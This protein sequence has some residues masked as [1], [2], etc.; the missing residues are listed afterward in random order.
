MSQ[1]NRKK[2]VKHNKRLKSKNFLLLYVEGMQII[3]DLQNNKMGKLE[4]PLNIK[5]TE[6]KGYYC[7][8]V[9]K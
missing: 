5:N 1:E 2:A 9:H 8:P 7:I 6:K 3:D 4:S